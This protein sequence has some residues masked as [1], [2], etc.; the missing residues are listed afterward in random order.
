MKKYIIVTFIFGLFTLF[1]GSVNAYDSG[2]TSE[3]PYSSTTGQ[4]CVA[5]ITSIECASG[6]LFS[7]LT[8]QPCNGS[9]SSSDSS[10]VESALTRTIQ[11]G[12]KGEDVKA[13]Q[14]ILQDQKYYLGKIDGSYGP[15]TKR[16]VKD[17]QEDNYLLVTGNVDS[18]TLAKMKDFSVF[19]PILSNTL[20]INKFGGPQSLNVGEQGTWTITVSDS[21]G[22]DLYY[23]IDW[24]DQPSVYA[25][26]TQDTPLFLSKQEGAF[27]HSYSQV[28]TYKV[29]VI[30]SNTLGQV[31]RAN[32]TV[33]V[34]P[35]TSLANITT[36]SP[37]PDAKVGASYST[38]ISA[39][40]GTGSYSWNI[41][42][43]Y[44]CSTI[45]CGSLPSGL[46]LIPTVCFLA[47]CQTPVS[48]SG[49]PSQAGT[50]IF[51]V[52]VSSDP[53]VKNG[54]TYKSGKQFSLTVG[55]VN[56]GIGTLSIEPSS[57]SVRG[58]ESKRVQAFY[59][60]ACP[61]GFSCIQAVQELNVTW[62]I[63][64]TSIANIVKAYSQ[65]AYGGFFP[66]NCFEIVSVIGVTPGS[67]E[68]T[69]T[70]IESN[71]NVLNKSI[72]VTVVVR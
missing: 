38:S 56:Q 31:A 6:D 49:T 39:T 2:C 48:I 4:L 3:G 20:S 10:S 72:P 62:S 70:Y 12:S 57:I 60:P 13:I 46:A 26:S 42:S 63:A 16:A 53:L 36:S 14:K 9:I 59:M 28:G 34:G 66:T 32:L 18:D 25:N 33:N 61:T 5:S 40:G 22:S 64:N 41:S 50:Y 58:G 19:T 44:G 30:V 1:A 17:F 27:T 7:S 24:G 55:G 21:G 45:F 15:R 43:P 65:C 68:L 69:A 67:T 54:P 8:G 37:L 47:P 11:V 29:T 52:E 23:T 71:G 51:V 35:T